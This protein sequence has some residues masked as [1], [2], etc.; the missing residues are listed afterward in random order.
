MFLSVKSYIHSSI[1]SLS[2]NAKQFT[3]NLENFKT[4]NGVPKI[5]IQLIWKDGNFTNF[6]V[7]SNKSVSVGANSELVIG[8]TRIFGEVNILRYLARVSSDYLNYET[9]P[10]VHEIDSLL[11][12]CYNILKAKT[13]TERASLLQVL[14][15]SLGKNQWLCGRNQISIADLA[16]YSAIKQATNPSEVN[17]NLGKWLERCIAC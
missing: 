13:K 2:E 14:N 6:C 1:S 17:A 16:G 8:Q 12:V 15:K 7:F 3:S 9:C 11:D 5:N 10:N 4:G